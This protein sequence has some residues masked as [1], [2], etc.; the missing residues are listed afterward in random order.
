M[1]RKMR[2]DMSWITDHVRRR[3]KMVHE[4]KTKLTIITWRDVLDDIHN[5]PYIFIGNVMLPDC[6][7]SYRFR[8]SFYIIAIWIISI[9]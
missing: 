8:V 1:A 3:I 6:A 5:D 4:Y 2:Y 7:I 9:S